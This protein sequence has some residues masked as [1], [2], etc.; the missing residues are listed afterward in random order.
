[1]NTRNRVPTRE[2][3][4]EAEVRELRSELRRLTLRVD[5]QGDQLSAG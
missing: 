1:M 4:L 3:R 5:E 2:E